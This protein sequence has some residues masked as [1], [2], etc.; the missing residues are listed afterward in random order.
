MVIES[1]SS[2]PASPAR[3]HLAWSR[4]SDAGWLVLRGRT[5]RLAVPVATVV[6]TVLSAVNE[7]SAVVRGRL[8]VAGVTRVIVNYAV[9]FLVASWGVLS[10]HRQHPGGNT[11]GAND[12]PRS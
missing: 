3:D 2:T 10:T 8:G 9:P 11:S 1:S 7:G 6:G 4:L 12:V 5:A